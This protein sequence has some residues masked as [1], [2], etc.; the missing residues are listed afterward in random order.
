MT[1][2]A[3]TCVLP[4]RR[5][6]RRTPRRRI[7]GLNLH[8]AA[9]PPEWCG[10]RRGQ[11][12]FIRRLLVRRSPPIPLRARDGRSRRSATSTSDGRASDRASSGSRNAQRCR[13]PRKRPVRLA[14]RRAVLEVDR[15]E[16]AG[17]L[18]PAQ[19]H[20]EQFA[21]RYAGGDAGEAAFAQDRASSVSCGRGRC[22]PAFR[23]APSG[24]VVDDGIASVGEALDAVGA[25]HQP[26]RSLAKGQV[27]FT[28]DFGARPPL[29]PPRA[30]APRHEPARNALEA[31]PPERARLR[32]VVKRREMPAPERN[33]SASGSAGHPLANSA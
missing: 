23:S 5:W 24:L 4:D 9:H 19:L 8:L 28:A 14:V 20:V 30:A 13:E 32:E 2:C 16:L 29:P 27:N 17:R 10:V 1:R 22:G 6:R 33:S 12:F 21:D 7:R 15:A 18:D 31:R 26:E 25:R 3:S 11:E